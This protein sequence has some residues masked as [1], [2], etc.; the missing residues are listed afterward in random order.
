M[1]K[2]DKNADKKRKTVAIKS[3]NTTHM[4]NGAPKRKAIEHNFT[5]APAYNK[6]A[7]QVVPKTDTDAY[8][9]RK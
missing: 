1:K 8:T 7:Y 2:S 4:G 6:G 5:V 9:N 3:M